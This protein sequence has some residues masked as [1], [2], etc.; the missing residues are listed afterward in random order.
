[1]N[2]T[3]RKTST[4]ITV[5][6]VVGTDAVH[7]TTLSDDVVF[8]VEANAISLSAEDVYAL[9]ELCMQCATIDD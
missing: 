3:I 1:M 6:E 5:A 9:R 4:G 7:A 8:D 2:I